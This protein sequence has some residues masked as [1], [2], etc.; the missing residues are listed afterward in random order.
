MSGWDFSP[1]IMLWGTVSFL[2]ALAVHIL[3]W[4]RGKPPREMAWLVGIFL[5]AP[6]GI[7]LAV[8]SL[9]VSGEGLPPAW[10]T[11]LAFIWHAALSSAYIMTYPPIQAGCPSLKI[12]L[13][14]HR[15][16]PKG[17]SLEEINELFPR[18]TMFSDRFDNLV[19]DGLVSWK[20]D[21]WGITGTGRLVARCFLAYRRLLKLPLGEG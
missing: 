19:E 2:A 9:S 12:V 17:L 3:V 18:Q 21:T 13:E 4:R 16:R 6:A 7:Y 14:I 8:Y 10:E 1:A 5:F 11:V 20:Y 15:N